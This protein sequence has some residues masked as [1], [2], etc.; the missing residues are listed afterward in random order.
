MKKFEVINPKG[1]TLASGVLQ[2]NKDQA[3]SREHALR[4]L[5][6]GLFLIEQPVQFKLGEIFGYDG[7]AGKALLAEM[8]PVEKTKAKSAKKAKPAAD[9]AD[10]Q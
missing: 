6:D 10:A 2:L 5:G 7:E 4:K 8:E 9:Q 1:V 3:G